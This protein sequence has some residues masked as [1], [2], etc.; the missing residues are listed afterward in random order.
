MNLVKRILSMILA[1]TILSLTV[2]LSV[3]AEDET[4]ARYA[5][6]T[7]EKKEIV[8]NIQQYYFWESNGNGKQFD[9]YQGKKG[10]WLGRKNANT[11]L[12]FN[13]SDLHWYSEEP[14]TVGVTFEYFDEGDENTWI[15]FR[16][17]GPNGNYQTPTEP[18]R[19][20][21][22]NE[23]KTATLVVDDMY[24]KNGSDGA[25][26]AL[27]TWTAALGGSGGDVFIHSVKVEEMFTL[28]PIKVTG[29]S[30]HLGNVFDVDDEKQMDL[31]FENITDFTGTVSADYVLVDSNEN[32]LLEGKTDTLTVP[33]NETVAH[34]IDFELPEC[35][36]YELRY[37]FRGEV[38]HDG[39]VAE[40]D[41]S[42]YALLSMGTLSKSGDEKNRRFWICGHSTWYG[43]DNTMEMVAKGGWGGNRAD[44]LGGDWDSIPLVNGKYQFNREK[45]NWDIYSE[46][47]K[48]NDQEI[49]MEGAYGRYS[50]YEDASRNSNTYMP[51]TEKE[52]NEYINY[53]VQLVQAWDSKEIGTPAR[54][55]IWNEP[56]NWYFN[57]SMETENPEYYA[58]LLKKAYPAIKSASPNTIVVGMITLGTAETWIEDALSHGALDYLDEIC[59][60][61]Y[62]WSKGKSK[63]DAIISGT[64]ALKDIMSKYGE[65][66][67]IIYSEIGWHDTGS[68]N[69]VGS[70][71]GNSVGVTSEEQAKN[72]IVLNVLS[73]AYDLTDL[74]CWYDL[75]NDGE[76]PLDSEDNFGMLEGIYNNTPF[77]A[78]L[79]YLASCAHNK[80]MP[81]AEYIDKIER[82]GLTTAAYRFKRTKGDN[83]AVMWTYNSNDTL[84]V[85]LGCEQVELVDLY[86]NSKGVVT[87]ETGIYTFNLIEEPLYV[88]GNFTKFEEV[89][90]GE[91]VISDFSESVPNDMIPVEIT[92]VKGRNLKVEVRFEDNDLEIVGDT[93]IKDG[94]ASF[95]LKSLEDSLG[96]HF[97]HI[98]IYD[99][100]GIYYSG[101]HTVWIKTPFKFEMTT[102]RVFENNAYRW[103]A[104]VKLTNQAY[105]A[106]L[107]G[108]IELTAPDNYAKN[109]NKV[110]F[111]DLRPKEE[112]TFYINLPE[113]VKKRTQNI[114]IQAALDTGYSEVY[115]TTIDFTTA[116]YA[117]TK[118]TLD[119][120]ISAD[121]WFG[122]W[123]Y[124]DNEE[125]ASSL[126]TNVWGG[127]ND[128]SQKAKFMWDEE[129]FYAAIVVKDNVFSQEYVGSNA[130]QGDGIQFGFEDINPLGQYE[131]TNFTE[132]GVSSYKGNIQGWRWSV[133]YDIQTGVVENISGTIKREDKTS[134]TIYEISIPWDEIFT[135]GY[136]ITKM[137]ELGFSYLI[138]DNDGTGRKGWIAYNGGIGSGV[139]NAKEFG[140]MKLIK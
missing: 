119:G 12:T 83:I 130:W 136:D 91:F 131:N 133:L 79:S 14:M 74:V 134:E 34:R 32:V 112:R 8:K 113:I 76:L 15:S 36:L 73:Q 107:N 82:N 103:Q 37:N 51:K 35:G 139:K 81:N 104:A 111:V 62:N 90:N 11:Y 31:T 23:W 18:L 10:F 101:E 135:E 94:K 63:F 127:P 77:A 126:G 70:Q 125:N 99:D 1:V 45:K 116:Y 86:G 118:P 122:E 33:A 54:I 98:K 46:L 50:I 24:L 120:N 19:M 2:P 106:H 97:V 5:E 140:R 109:A 66:K 67:P 27:A 124:S 87:S 6:Y 129:N 56:N 132:L 108:E 60:H 110:K 3:G 102:E 93:N 20:T 105:T 80:L 84:T 22:T 117:N 16:Y 61:P 7:V 69:E 114:S 68:L 95:M 38:P 58:N 138:N 96:E 44:F 42:G 92:D 78:K 64:N 59:V 53:C 100:N 65:V 72:A 85:E 4:T 52:I 88:I 137:S 41:E 128:I 17:Q 75:Q 28:H 55:E 43:M 121:E 71:S 29:K 123:V 57:K 21:G 49:I 89:A 47:F 26:M 9:E 40:F 13:I 48:E 30:E 25:D 39:E 115:E